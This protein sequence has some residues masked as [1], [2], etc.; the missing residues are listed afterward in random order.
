MSRDRR[1]PSCGNQS[2]SAQADQL[3]EQDNKELER[4]SIRNM[5]DHRDQDTPC[6]PISSDAMVLEADRLR[7][8]GLPGE[9]R[10]LL[11]AVLADSP[12]H[13]EALLVAG[14]LDAV[15][16]PRTAI[17]HLEK[18]IACQPSSLEG[19]FWLGVVYYNLGR[20]QESLHYLRRLV[21]INP[22]S[23]Y[24]HQH[25]GKTLE[26]LGRDD[27]AF[28]S[29]RK[30]LSLNPDNTETLALTGVIHAKYGRLEE[31]AGF[32]QQALRA[33][34]NYQSAHACL[35]RALVEMNRDEE[36][37]AHFQEALRLNPADVNTM[38]SL[39]TLF[40]KTSNIDNA[41]QL[42]LKAQRLNPEHA[43]ILSAMGRVRNAQG[44]SPEA[45]A[46]FR[47]AYEI[48]PSQKDIASNLLFSL[49]Y[50]TDVP[51]EYVSAEHVRISGELFPESPLSSSLQLPPEPE[52]PHVLRIGYLSADFHTHSVSCF[53]E[54][55]LQHHDRSRFLPILYYG[56]GVEDDT[57]QRMRELAFK[58]RQTVG[59]PAQELSAMIESDR[60]DILVELS[61]H[62][63]LNRLDVC[64][65]RP[66]P[67]QVSWIGYP[68]STGMPQIDYYLSD[69]FCDPEGMTDHLF[70]ETIYRLPR[71]FCVYTP[72]IEF[73]PVRQIPELQTQGITFGCFNNFA[74][75]NDP[76]FRLWAAILK[77]VPGSRL[78]LK[79]ASLA[80]GSSTHRRI[81]DLF[82]REGVAVDRIAAQ[83]VKKSQYDHL[84]QYSAIDIALDTY[85]YHGTTTTCEALWMGVPVVTLAGKCHASRVGVSLL[86]G[87]GLSHLVAYSEEEYIDKAI[88]LAQDRQQ[89]ENL[90]E[91]LRLMMAQSPLM[92][93]AGIT[94]DVESAYCRMFE[95]GR[96]KRP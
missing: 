23:H 60:I 33:D 28:D 94:R 65:L 66:A 85:P 20:Y 48:D 45:V 59:V 51:P 32:F 43:G 4:G 27:A 19:L 92:D 73:P 7:Q 74:K 21:L 67:V 5:P 53:F 38:V 15:D 29:Y 1:K 61:G 86:S 54:P 8:Q 90:R 75:T 22:E 58:W 6:S 47:R 57:T 50:L 9:A 12:D 49:N 56:K 37:Y 55:I 70:S 83:V 81:L 52:S 10:L 89:R 72:P 14:I 68:H 95:Q 87:V 69:R 42:L 63:G 16:D 84:D 76:L 18:H 25:L 31:A 30:A 35:G 36:G 11:N 91:N 62:S 88:Q 24:A 93:G 3:T 39:A 82:S 80:E 26:A 96:R 46:A 40:I 77:N 64:A 41:E 44:R 79:S 34:P 13:P 78:V 71:V 2:V 17:H